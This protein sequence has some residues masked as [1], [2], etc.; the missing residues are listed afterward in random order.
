MT[1]EEYGIRGI[2][3]LGLLFFNFFTDIGANW[4]VRS[5][6]FS[7]TD[8]KKL[9][10]YISTILLSSF[11]LKLLM[12]LVIFVGKDFIFPIFFKEWSN[13]YSN[14]LDIQLLVF[15]ISFTANTVISVL[16][17]EEKALRY[18]LLLT[19]QFLV[20]NASSLFFLIYLKYGIK[21]LFLGDLLAEI[22][23][24]S[25]ALIFIKDK[26]SFKL[27]K[28]ALFDIIKI[29]LPAVPKNIF[30]QIQLN[31]NKYLTA[32]YLAPADLGIFSKSTFLNSG[33]TNI[34]RSFANTISPKN[35]ENLSNNRKDETT[36]KKVLILIYLIS[37]IYILG[38]FFM[39]DFLQIIHV[40]EKFL[41]CGKYAPFY[42]FSVLVSSFSVM[43]VNN[44]LISG[45]T[46]YFSIRAVIAAVIS[47]FSG[48]L[49]VPRY[50]LN[51]AIISNI[52]AAVFS[53]AIE[54]IVSERLLSYKTQISYIGFLLITCTC[55][56]VQV[57]DF[58]FPYAY[59]NQ[60]KFLISGLYILFIFLIDKYFVNSFNWKQYI[61]YF[62]KY[63]YSY[64][65][66]D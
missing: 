1:P 33:L 38:I 44:I 52:I 42:A 10:S 13:F 39:R 11:I 54:I 55:L 35:L 16:I 63:I 40:H 37:T 12:S 3:L 5:K 46:Y 22:F 45:K 26:L 62:K 31:I 4:V 29:G 27:T 30:G 7:F 58:T 19:T 17:L 2:V 23:F 47:L 21:S 8:P 49:L 66:H 59:T 51:G 14:L 9:S 60:I 20:G 24:A 57:F 48:I 15:V 34:Q 65:K 43:F 61:S 56:L 28:I 25:I 41:I 18:S 50:G 64:K 53:L 6:F 32:V 36:G